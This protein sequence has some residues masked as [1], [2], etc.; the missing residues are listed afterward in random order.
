VN[1][2]TGEFFNDTWVWDGSDWAEVTCC[3]LPLLAGHTLVGF[4]S[5]SEVILVPSSATINTWVWNGAAWNEIAAYPNPPRVDSRSVYDREH[6]RIILFG[7]FGD[8]SYS[9]ETWVFDGQA[10]N[11]ISLSAPLLGRFGHVFFYDIQRRSLIVFG[12]AARSGKLAD[13]WE[14]NLPADLS[15][16]LMAAAPTEHFAFPTRAA[17]P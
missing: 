2:L 1:T 10:W 7:G 11:Y 17:T 16:L 6:G 15:A 13:T 8:A 3:S 4:G 9:S 5:R 12:G 14:H